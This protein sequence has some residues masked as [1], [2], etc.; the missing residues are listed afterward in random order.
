MCITILVALFLLSGCNGDEGSGLEYPTRPTTAVAERG[1]G[2]GEEVDHVIEVNTYAPGDIRHGTELIAYDV[3]FRNTCAFQVWVVVR[4]AIFTAA[5]E[6]LAREDFA[7]GI[8]A[9]GTGWLCRDSDADTTTFCTPG[10]TNAGQGPYGVKWRYVSCW[11]EEFADS[12][13][14]TECTPRWPTAAD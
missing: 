3:K 5:D 10:S 8:P 13:A 6:L 12:I 9:R 7:E 2:C 4:V 1:A 11:D 14:D